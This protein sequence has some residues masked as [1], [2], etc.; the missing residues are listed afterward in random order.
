MKS[1]VYSNEDKVK[2]NFKIIYVEQQRKILDEHMDSIKCV[3]KF[4]TNLKDLT[5][6]LPEIIAK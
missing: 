3:K 4:L 2:I 5:E 6:K 1:D